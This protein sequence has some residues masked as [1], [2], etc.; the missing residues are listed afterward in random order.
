MLTMPTL[1]A[2]ETLLRQPA[3][4]AVGWAL[5]QFVWQG[6]AIGI[7]TAIA[8]ASLR[9]N[10]ADVRYVVG[11]VGLALMLTLPLATGVQKYQVLRA[12]AADAVLTAPASVDAPVTAAVSSRAAAPLGST[13][14]SDAGTRTWGAGALAHVSEVRIEP[15]LPT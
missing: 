15:L 8:L 7:L 4:Q 5:L 11:A 9:R 12:D 6:A 10:A 1:P 14:V 3:A 13:V 2:I